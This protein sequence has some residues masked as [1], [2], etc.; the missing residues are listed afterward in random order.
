MRRR[1][2]LGAGAVVVAAAVVANRPAKM[3]GPHN[4]Y[5]TALNRELKINRLYK[6]SV[7]IDLDKLDDNIMKLKRLLNPKVAYRVVVKSLPSVDLLD[8]IMQKSGT[9]RLMVFH[10][11]F[12]NLI[13]EKFPSSD[14]LLG[15]P[16]PVA[17]AQLFYEELDARSDFDPSAQLQWLIDSP[18]R[19]QQYL[20]LAKKINQKLRVNF[21]L[22]VGL[23]R[24][25]L[26]TAAELNA[27]LDEVKAHPQFVEFSGFMGYDP[28]VV[29]IPS[30]L[31]SHEDAYRESQ[32]QYQMFLDAVRK[33]ALKLDMDTLCLNG[34]G[35]PSLQLHKS[36]TVCNELS[37]GSC[38][39][40]PTD[41]D[42]PSLDSM[43]PASYIATPV[44]KKLPGVRV[45]GIE[46]IADLIP[47]W[48]P[49]REQ[50]FFVYGGKW[51]ANYESPPGLIDNTTFGL[52][53]NQQIAN[54][55][56]LVELEVD[57]FAFLRPHQSE[58]VFLQFE[59]IVTIRQG[60]LDKKWPVFSNQLA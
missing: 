14:V 48:N 28:H 45:P 4:A 37:A 19:L 6:P 54:G 20:A 39:V 26:T 53:T 52:S 33:H 10:Q 1:V 31:K 50:T 22:D 8:Y 17:A 18:Q 3:G 12:L 35:S 27:M 7:I 56:E 57:D 24:G 40:K 47:I 30:V 43:I 34:A 23:H 36:N 16:M 51:M 21:E 60:R 32:A 29:K 55:S 11:P 46:A 41:F 2:F 44:L 42:I 5:F 38:L 25:G 9:T 58:F 15:K 59:S 13:A 49:N